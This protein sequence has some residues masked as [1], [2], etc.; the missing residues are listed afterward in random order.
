MHLQRREEGVALLFGVTGVNDDILK[1][2]KIQQ[3]NLLL[4]RALI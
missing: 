4:G 3:I 2:R 1:L